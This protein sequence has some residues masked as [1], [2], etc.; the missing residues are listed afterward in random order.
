[1]NTTLAYKTLNVGEDA[2][3]EEIKYAYRK[4]ALYLHPDKND[5]ERDGVKFKLV[6]DA[7]HHLKNNQRHLNAKTRSSSKSWAY[8]N[9]QT[10]SKQT[11]NGKPS[12]GANFGKSPPE[13]DWSKY[14]KDFEAN[15]DF[16]KKYE[17]DFWEK[18]DAWMS[19]AYK[20]ETRFESKK[21]PEQEPNVSVNVDPT[22][23]IGCCSC[24]TIAPEVFAVDKK[25]KMNPKSH[26]HNEK[27]AKFEKIMDAA[28]TCPTKAIN[29]DEKETQRRL[30]PW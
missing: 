24:E 3:F 22:L 19:G 20:E 6:T 10:K 12:W 7:Y 27:G 8:T 21:Q 4:L 2:S 17:K 9:T 1:L 15:Q 26:V 29:V 16:W 30:Y 11:F 13:E 14:T 25:I 28:Q 23:C 5:I 18:Y